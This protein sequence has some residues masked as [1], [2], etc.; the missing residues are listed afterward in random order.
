MARALGEEKAAAASLAEVLGVVAEEMVV[1]VVRAASVVAKVAVAASAMGSESPRTLQARQLSG[2]APRRLGEGA[3][4]RKAGH[5]ARR[6][7]W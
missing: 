4:S 2:S 3:R 7:R 5:S 1:M 6:T